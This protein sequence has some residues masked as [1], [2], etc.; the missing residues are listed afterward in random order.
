MERA[1]KKI[2]YFLLSILILLLIYIFYKSEIYWQGSQRKYYLKYFILISFIILFL[3]FSFFYISRKYNI[4]LTI[5]LGSIFFSLYLFEG[6]LKINNNILTIN[7]KIKLNQKQQKEYDTRTKIEIYNDLKKKTSNTTVVIGAGNYISNNNLPIL[8]LSGKSYSQTIHCNEQGYY[9]IYKS[10]RYG[11]NNPDNEW[12]KKEIKYFLIGDSF[13]HGACVKEKNDIASFLRVLS[14]ESSLNLGYVGNGPLSEYAIL[15]EYLKPNVKNIIWFFYE[16]NDTED[17]L[18]EL[19]SEI[20]NKYLKDGSYS[21]N[22]IFKQNLIDQLAEEEIKKWHGQYKVKTNLTEFSRFI[23]LSDLRTTIFPPRRAKLNDKFRV[24][25]ELTKKIA[26]ENNSNLYFV[27]LPQYQSINKQNSNLYYEV[28]NIIES[29]NITFID[30]KKE[31]FDKERD[32]FKLFPFSLN[33]HYNEDGYKKI[34][35]VIKKAINN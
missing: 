32:P 7:K 12:D 27:Y 18:N 5:I 10:D 2:F 1:K 22:L 16:A 15:R 17:L 35:T 34:A 23:K 29:L 26:T 3:N 21:Q 28:K 9:S 24:I 20:L 33:G 4:Y 6:F 11:F 19:K 14:R 25:M 30:I 31:V 13:P 8:P